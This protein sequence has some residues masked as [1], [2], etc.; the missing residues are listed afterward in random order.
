M[1]MLVVLVGISY[2]YYDTCNRV[3]AWGPISIV[4]RQFKIWPVLVPGLDR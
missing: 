1:T 2:S 3:D 4:P